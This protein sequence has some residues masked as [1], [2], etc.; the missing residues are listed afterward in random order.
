MST[1]LSPANE[2][3]IQEAIG[4]GEFQNREEGAQRSGRDAQDAG[5]RSCAH[6]DEGT[7]QLRAG[8]YKEY[9]REGLTA[10]SLR[11]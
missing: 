9:D 10:V 3:F 1:D 11:K 4:R 2:M 8:E 5:K 7:R 6:I